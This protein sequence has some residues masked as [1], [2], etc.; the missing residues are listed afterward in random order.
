MSPSEPFADFIA[1]FGPNWSISDF[2]DWVLAD[3]EAPTPDST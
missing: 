1:E 2:E 3:L